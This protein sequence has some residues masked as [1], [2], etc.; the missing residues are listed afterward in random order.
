[1]PFDLDLTESVLLIGSKEE[2]RLTVRVFDS[3]F[4]LTQPRGKQY[5]GPQPESIFYTPSSGIWQNVWLESV[6]S[7]KIADSSHGT[8]LFPELQKGSIDARIAVQGRRAQ[9]KCFVE[10]KVSLGGHEISTSGRKELPLNEGFIRFDQPMRLPKDRVQGMPEEWGQQHLLGNLDSFR[11][12]IALWSPDHPALYDL[13]MTLFN[14]SNQPI[15]S[16]QTTVGMRSLTWTRGDGTLRLNGKPYFHALFLDQGYWPETL[17]T[18]PS[19]SSLKEDILLSKRMGF[20]GCRKHQ[21]VEDPLFYYYAD[22]L[23]FLVWGEMASPYNF[24]LDMVERFNQEWMEAVKRDI[25]HPSIVAWTPVNESWGY[26][27]LGGQAR[28]RDHIRS[29]YYMTKTL[30]PTRPINDN[31]GWEHVI[32]DLSTFHNYADARGMSERCVSLPAILT[33]GRNMFLGP[34]HGP[35]GEFDPGSQHTRGA[36]ILCTEFGGVNISVQ[37][38]DSRKGNWGY[39]TAKDS[40]DLLKRVEDLIMAVVKEGHVCGIVWTQFCDVEQEMN[41]LYTFDRKEKIPSRE[42]KKVI[43]RARRAYFGEVEA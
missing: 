8:I 23:G 35:N 3:A 31:C 36:P 13:T 29:L 18:P 38:D 17:M 14:S 30:D 37:N 9:Q 24:S 43:E 28:Q 20:N 21:K 12:G 41:G 25:N 32:T 34:I 42:M 19:A 1:V 40:Q 16:I 39:T 27:D 11:D 22:R 5:W 10:L 2:Y 7:L 4:D 6:P 26:T 33:R 15:D